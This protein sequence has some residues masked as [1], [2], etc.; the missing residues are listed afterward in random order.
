MNNSLVELDLENYTPSD[1][2]VRGTS[3]RFEGVSA[4]DM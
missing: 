3:I 4:K 1:F 2:C